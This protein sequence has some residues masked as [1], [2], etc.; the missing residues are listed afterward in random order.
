MSRFPIHTLDTAPAESRSALDALRQEIGFLPNLAA[1]MAASPTLIEG[2]TTL[3]SI[4]GRS[5]FSAVERETISL[6]VSFENNCTYCMAAHST[7]AK[8]AGI[9]EPALEALRAG[10]QPTDERL[11]ALSTFTRH[12]LNTRGYATVEATQAFLDAGFTPAHALSTIAVVAF[13][14]LANYAHNLT[15]CAIDPQFQPQLWTPSA[16]SRKSA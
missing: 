7:F 6:V 11:R 5:S 4:L 8:K 3:R 13:T 9:S 1:T 16:S 15:G 12:V 10:G 2:F 14:T